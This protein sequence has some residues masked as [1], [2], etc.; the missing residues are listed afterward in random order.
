M[1]IVVLSDSHGDLVSCKL[2]LSLHSD[3]DIVVHLGDTDED[4][5]EIAEDMKNKKFI[6]VKGN[7]WAPY[8]RFPECLTEIICERK[9]FFT[10]G[11][12]FR[13]KYSIE[14]LLATG[15]KQGAE[16]ILFGHT[17]VPYYEFIDGIHVLNPGS[18]KKG[19]MGIVDITP[20]GVVCFTKNID[21]NININY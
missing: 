3:A 9:I 20:A 11:H 13:V 14:N 8:S 5:E 17:H 12:L 18:I 1:R 6:A 16:I 7:A 15:K 2:A 10:H 21:K 4:A 19:S